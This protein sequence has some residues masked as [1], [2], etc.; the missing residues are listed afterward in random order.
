VSP[1]SRLDRLSG[2]ALP[3]LVA[4][5]LLLRLPNLGESLWYDEVFSTRV[6]L[7]SGR[8]LGRA[9]MADVH[10]PLYSLFMFLWVHAFGDSELSIR[11]PPLTCGLASLALTGALA[12]RFV[13]RPTALLAVA[14]LCLSPVH[15]WYS[16][17]ARLYSAALCLALLALLAFQKLR[18]T[19][20]SRRG[21]LAYGL[22]LGAA[23]MTH[24]Y[25]AAIP[26]V[27]SALSLR[28]GRAGRKIL[29][30]NALV[31]LL[32][33]L[34]LGSKAAGSGLATEMH[35]LRLFTPLELCMLFFNWFLL[36][37]ALWT[38][39]P[40]AHARHVPGML[41]MLV[42]QTLACLVFLRGL[43]RIARES[44]GAPLLLGC[45]LLPPLGLL[46]L[47]AAGFTKTYIER[48]LYLLLPLF[49]IA[50]ARGVTGWR[51]RWASVAGVT[52]LLAV[53]AAAT[54]AYFAKSEQWTVYKQNPDWR[55]VARHL[56][57]E[58]AAGAHLVL[59]GDIAFPLS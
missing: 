16:Q 12:R 38:V 27:T 5:G 24:Y 41:A 40:Y 30:A 43:V 7:D 19:P 32:L 4:V 3:A 56:D 58:R 50:M 21:L 46:G 8:A 36:G 52:A 18:E 26:I 45:L 51:S 20:D 9:V 42:F 31:L 53:S 1:T 6:M 2:V 17:E 25:A 33:A 54:G 37:N 59:Y 34:W 47:G 14:L 57:R 29:V 55:S 48:S 39:P 15:I 10:P 23:V 13:D 22:A 44:P 28:R 11:V 49:A 35:H